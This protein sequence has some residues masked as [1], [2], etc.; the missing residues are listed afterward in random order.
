MKAELELILEA[1]EQARDYIE[2]SLPHIYQAGALQS[3]KCDLEQNSNAIA[4]AEKLLDKIG[5]SRGK[6]A[7]I[8]P[9]Q[10][11]SDTSRMAAASVAPSFSGV[12]LQVLRAISR[13]SLT[14][15]QGQSIVGM[16]GNSYRPCRVT[17]MD[18][19]YVEDTGSRRKTASGR[20]AVVWGITAEGREYLESM[21]ETRV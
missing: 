19:G 10:R 4:A 14:D 15:E 9:H 16:T 1:L 6:L 13:H 3:A 8:P 2:S 20:T 12:R 11:H 17:L 21:D 7:E 5:R 18:A